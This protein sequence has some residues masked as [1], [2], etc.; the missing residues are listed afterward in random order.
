MGGVGGTSESAAIVAAQ[1]VAINGA[2]PE[3]HALLAP[4]DLYRLA[5]AHPEAFRQITG[6]NDRR[7]FD[8]TLRPR[9]SPVP[10]DYRGIIPTPAPAVYGCKPA[11][12]QGCLVKKGYNAVTGIGS[13][14]EKAAV[15]ALR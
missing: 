5:K 9:P 3:P 14:Q 7:I 10:K 11:Q 6:E 2:V 12:P 13:I 8:N 15:E 1:L 4:G